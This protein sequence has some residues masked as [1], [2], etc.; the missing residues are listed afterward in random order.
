[1]SMNLHCDKLT[2]WQTPTYITYMCM[3]YDENGEPDGGNEGVRRRYAIWVRS[4]LNGAWSDPEDYDWTRERVEEHLEELD[5]LVDP[6]FS[7][8]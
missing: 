5:A 3:S 4:T 7:I 2:L 8:G 6:E 1:M